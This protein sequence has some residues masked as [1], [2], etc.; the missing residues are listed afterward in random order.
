MGCCLST[1]SRIVD[2]GKAVEKQPRARRTGARPT[3]PPPQAYSEAS[4]RVLSA[5]QLAR[6]LPEALP[7]LQEHSENTDS[8]NNQA[9]GSQA[10]RTVPLPSKMHRYP[11]FAEDDTALQ[12][13]SFT[14]PV[15]GIAALRHTVM[16]PQAAASSLP[17]STPIEGAA[18][19]VEEDTIPAHPGSS[20][21]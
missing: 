6:R 9:A 21:A 19:A 12:A 3:F 4:S 15:Y 13:S 11:S 17:H 8:S 20:G 16:Q 14:S 5:K 1:S 18:E 2:P 7:P 10:S